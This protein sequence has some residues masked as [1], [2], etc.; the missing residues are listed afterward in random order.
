LRPDVRSE[1]KG[2]CVTATEMIIPYMSSAAIQHVKR[3]AREHG[4][5]LHELDLRI[6]LNH[7]PLAGGN[8]RR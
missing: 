7:G 2:S 3:A 6:K 5:D 8:S 1:A 4:A